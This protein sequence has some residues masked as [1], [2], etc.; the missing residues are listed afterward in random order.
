MS[1]VTSKLQVTV[2]KA[3][4]VRYGIH[5]GDEIE[6]VVA[7]DSIRVVP[8]NRKPAPELDASARVEL[9]D[10]ATG[11]QKEHEAR[12]GSA[13]AHSVRKK[14]AQGRGWTREELY[15]HARSR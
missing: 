8:V 11:R 5:P 15:G 4:A 14:P 10:Q 12:T 9:F 3:V 6:W 13:K 2:P 1:K 7:E